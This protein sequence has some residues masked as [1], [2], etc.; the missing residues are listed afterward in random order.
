MEAGGRNG[1]GRDGTEQDG[2]GGP[3]NGTGGDGRAGERDGRGREGT[4]GPGKRTGRRRSWSPESEECRRA[5]GR[6]S[7]F[8]AFLLKNQGLDTDSVVWEVTVGSVRVW[9]PNTGLLCDRGP[10][11]IHTALTPSPGL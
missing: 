7:P 5:G 8:V 10:Y 6:Q 4:G 2:T 1:T 3:G 11:P 9:K